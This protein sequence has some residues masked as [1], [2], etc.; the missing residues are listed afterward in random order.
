VPRERPYHR[1]ATD[2]RA[3]IKRGDLAPG[4]RL[5][6]AA[7]LRARYGVASQTVANA[8]DLLKV[9]GLI[10]GRAGS[11]VYVRE[12]PPIVRLA[13]NR[14]SRS[15]R[16]AGRGF[17]LTDAELG[18]WT[19]RSDVTVSVE[20]ADEDTAADLRIAAGDPVLVRDRI[21]YA[22]DEPVQLATSYLPSDLTEGTQIEHENSGPGGIYA[23]LE[24]AG[25]TLTHYRETV[26]QS[27]A[28]Q[29]EAEKLRV[30]PGAALWRIVR[31]AYTDNRPVEV[32]HISACCDRV[33]LIYELPAE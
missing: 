1:I 18:G 30:A 4:D 23:R 19:P 25:H 22:D 7:E 2:L 15:E 28:T 8:L 6:T 29:T 24:D 32:N 21:M 14:L 26:S 3:A 27:P 13:R 16:Q 33:Q 31:T 20:T 12:R 10:T 5:P 9:E 11:G 17:F